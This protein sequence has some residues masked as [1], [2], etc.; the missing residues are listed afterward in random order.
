MQDAGEFDAIVIGSGLGS[1]AA[2]VTLG[3]RDLRVLVLERLA[4]LGGAA[5]VYRH[6]RLTIEASLHEIDG[7]T[8]RGPGSVLARLGL[9]GKVETVATDAFYEAR[10]GP[11]PVPVR[12]PHGLEAAEASLA[13]ALPGARP[14]LT[15]HFRT[16]RAIEASLQ[17]FEARPGTLTALRLAGRGQLWPMLSAIPRTLSGALDPVFGA[18]EAAKLALAAPIAYFDDDPR[19]LSF[20]LYAGVWSRYV[21]GGSHYLRGGSAALTRAMAEQLRGFGGELRR[22]CTVEAIRLD[23]AGRACGVVWRDA[24]GAEHAARAPRVLAGAAPQA[25]ADML[26]EPARPRFQRSFAGRERSISLF[27]LSL[28]LSRPAADFGVNTYSTFVFPPELE[29]LADYPAA[30]ASF[31]AAPEGRVPPFVLADYGRLDSGLA[32]PG[33]AH[34]V[35]LCGVDRLAWWAGLDEAAEMDRR[36]R[37]ID[38]LIAAA[39]RQFPGLAAAVTQAEIAT[40]RTMQTRLGTPEG[41]V[42]GFRPTPRRLFGARPSAATPVPGLFLSSAYT[43]SGGYAGAM[44]GGLMAARAALGR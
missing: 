43:V 35:S 20:L 15:R 34:L 27:T 37:W 1:L 3:Q 11:L 28:G 30:A 16:L 44:Q 19:R 24:E 17:A 41:E 9:A 33:D 14:G 23:A 31:G 40:A 29:R 4:N 38:A 12:V 5:T 8:L 22:R 6:G 39:D 26:P 32:Q 10:G 7:R 13:T 18:N 42:Y 25:V 36:A 21:A 2:A